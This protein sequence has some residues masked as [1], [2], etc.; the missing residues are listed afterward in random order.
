MGEN[1]K[2]SINL[3]TTIIV[4]KDSQTVFAYMSDL[5]LDKNWRKEI[6]ETI[7]AESHLTIHSIAIEDSCLSK[8]VPHHK[9]V[10]RCVAYFPGKQVVYQSLPDNMFWLQNTREVEQLENNRTKIVYK[11]AFD[12]A[13]VKYAL[14]FKLP[15]FI[16]KYY[17]Q[18]TMLSY[19]KKLKQL[20]ENT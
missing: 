14:G 16:I 5:R 17:T 11:L 7:V 15:V 8:K 19:L 10:L 20:L 13:V 3:V 1:N 9:A 18:A 6:N 4:E 12:P 2:T